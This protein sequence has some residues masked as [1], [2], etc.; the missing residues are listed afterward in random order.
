[1]VY[2]YGMGVVVTATFGIHNSVNCKMKHMEVYDVC[3]GTY[4]NQ[5]GR[6]LCGKFNNIIL[7]YWLKMLCTDL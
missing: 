2:T 6:K 1:M 4:K 3:Y 7:I 5:L